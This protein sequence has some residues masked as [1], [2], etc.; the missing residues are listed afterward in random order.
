MQN[1]KK[2]KLY[3]FEYIIPVKLSHLVWEK[4]QYL[5]SHINKVEWSGCTFY[6]IEGDLAKPETVYIKVED[7]I[8]LDKGS[9]GFTEYSFDSRVLS[10]IMEKDYFHLKTGHLHSHHE[11]K[12]FFSGTDTDE[13][14]EN[15]EHI[16]PYL[17]IIVNNRHEFSAKIAFRIKTITPTT[18]QFQNIDNSISTISSLSEAEYV[19]N[20]NCKI[21]LPEH[22]WNVDETFLNQ[23]TAINKPKPTPNIKFH[24]PKTEL[25]NFKNTQTDLFNESSWW[26]DNN[27]IPSEMV[28]TWDASE[29]LF[30]K[31]LRLGVDVP[32]DT[33]EQALED[34]ENSITQSKDFN[35]HDYAASIKSKF[36]TWVTKFYQKPFILKSELDNIWEEFIDELVFSADEFVVLGELIELLTEE[37]TL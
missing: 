19:A 5:C 7:M 35:L 6:S 10:Y 13:V 1:I 18:F 34:L 24:K 3:D 30:C 28:T 22:T 4:I 36:K 26:Q 11:M 21:I 15:S 14:I 12:T 17:S 33:L 8:P 16:K 31:I 27:A 25:S 20:Y 23:F 32:N 37:N 9:T 2:L 29:S